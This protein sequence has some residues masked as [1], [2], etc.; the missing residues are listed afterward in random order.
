MIA[1]H[2]LLGDAWPGCADVLTPE[3]RNGLET[4][5]QRYGLEARSKIEQRRMELNERMAAIFDPA[6][7][8]DFVITASNPDV[9]FSA[10][11]PLPK[12]FGGI[13]AG[14]GNNGRLTFPA[15]LHG[16][17]AVSIPAGFVDDDGARLPVGLQVVGRHFDE[18]RLLE[19]SLMMERSR[20]WPLTSRADVPV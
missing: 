20:P 14:A 13:Q 2:A 6:D 15:N 12:T 4:A 16:S 7:G 19:L 5:P 1:I 3:M 17:P 11:G 9:A 8:V 10:D 18:Q